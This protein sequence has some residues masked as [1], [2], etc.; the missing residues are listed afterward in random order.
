M[1]ETANLLGTAYLR[2]MQKSVFWVAVCALLPVAAQSQNGY[3]QNH[4]DYTL[5]VELNPENHNFSGW[6]RLKYTN[7]SPDTLREVYYHL[8]FLSLIHI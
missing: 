7:N 4:V 8:Y 5:S 2:G 6:E 3:W 1:S